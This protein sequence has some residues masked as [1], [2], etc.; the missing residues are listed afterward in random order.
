M[1]MAHKIR[2]RE[3]VNRWVARDGPNDNTGLDAHIL[4]GFFIT[5]PTP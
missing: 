3:R 4:D 2:E 1:A 5:F